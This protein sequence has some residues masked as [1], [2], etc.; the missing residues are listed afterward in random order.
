MRFTVSKKNKG[1]EET[2]GS[3]NLK[4]EYVSE[5][6]KEETPK[7]DSIGECTICLDNLSDIMLP[8][9]H[10]FCNDCL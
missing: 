1:E 5:P 4:V 7:V 10:A 8:C 3:S 6:K 2:K 9:L